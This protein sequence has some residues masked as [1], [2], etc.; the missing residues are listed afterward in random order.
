[1][2]S[3]QDW[4]SELR[5]SGKEVIVEGKKDRQA[6]E[7]FGIENITTLSSQPLFAV[8]EGV[9]GRGKDVVILTDMDRKGKELY[10]RLAKRLA[11]HGVRIDRRFRGF[12]QKQRLSHI[13]GLVSFAQ[14]RDFPGRCRS[15]FPKLKGKL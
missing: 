6:L 3:V 12:L 1:M 10:G 5:D 13:E 2:E 8:V 7:F 4:L 11:D 15:R 9:A 14:S